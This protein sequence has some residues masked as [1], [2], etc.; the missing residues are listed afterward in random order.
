MASGSRT[1]LVILR[2]LFVSKKRE[3]KRRKEEK[4][5]EENKEERKEREEGKQLEKVLLMLADI[6]DI[7]LVAR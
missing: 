1:P 6:D 7:T 2:L 4:I 3:E 5:R